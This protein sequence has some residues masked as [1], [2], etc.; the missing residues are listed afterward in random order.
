MFSQHVAPPR[1]SSSFMSSEAG[2]EGG[3]RFNPGSGHRS[4]FSG[5]PGDAGFTSELKE[6]VSF[7]VS[8]VCFT[9]VGVETMKPATGGGLVCVQL[10]QR[11]VSLAQDKLCDE[12][13]AS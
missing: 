11:C 10:L 5:C 12:E 9:A 2:T 13:E 1:L 3:G 7:E 8:E 4:T 6:S